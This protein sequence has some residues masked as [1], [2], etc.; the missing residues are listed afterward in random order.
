[1]KKLPKSITILGR[2]YQL[3]IVNEK[4]MLSIT[5]EY[6]FGCVD[7]NNNTISILEGQTGEQQLGV[8]IHEVGH[9]CHMIVG[10]EQIIS[11][12]LKEILCESMANCM[13]DLVK[14][15]NG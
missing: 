15:L 10:T 2:K 5:N 1:M 4:K 11:N 6:A 14:S 3:R 12:E 8:L 13:I 7:F 9:I